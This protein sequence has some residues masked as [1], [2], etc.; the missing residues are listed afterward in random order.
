MILFVRKQESKLIIEGRAD[1]LE[2]PI[3]DNKL[4]PTQKPVPLL[5]MLIE[6]TA[7]PYQTLVDPF[8]GSGSSIVAGVEMKMKCQGCDVL[9]ESYAITLER[10]V[11]QEES[12]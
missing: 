1:W 10:L 9:T 6:R 12:K 2:C 11:G 5:K 4:H 3:V 8:M 7:L